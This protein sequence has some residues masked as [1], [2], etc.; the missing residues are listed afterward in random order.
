MIVVY[1]DG[2]CEPWNPR[3]IATYGY[4]I[5]RDGKI[6]HK[7][8]GLAC[9][10]FSPKASNN[11]AEYTAMI[12]ALKFLVE[13]RMTSE[14]VVVR[15]DS[16]LTIRQMLGVYSVRASRIIPLYKR[17]ASLVKHFRDIRFEWVPR[18]KNEEADELSHEAYVEYIDNNPEVFERIKHT[19]ATEKQKKV[20]DKLGIKYDKYVGKREASRLIGRALRMR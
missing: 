9:E 3:G 17:A 12:E 11:V 7:G 1:F 6:H 18:E 5:Y 2:A 10:P 8:K 15:G 16:Q 13:N 19:L 4:V 14:K 20:M